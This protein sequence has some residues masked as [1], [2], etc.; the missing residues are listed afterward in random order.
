MATGP[1]TIDEY[2]ATVSD[3]KR[4]ALE[5]L[6]QTIRSAAPDAVECIAWQMPSFRQGKLL[7]GFAAWANHCALYPMSAKTVAAHEHDLQGFETSPGTIRFTPDKPLPTELVRKL[8][9]ARIAEN[10]GKATPSKRSAERA[11]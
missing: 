7:V 5:E 4:A 8:V 2:L 3:D 11:S 6:R 9:L 1:K 10:A